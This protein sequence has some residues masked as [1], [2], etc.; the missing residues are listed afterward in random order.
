MPVIRQLATINAYEWTLFFMQCT[1]LGCTAVM[2]TGSAQ[3]IK[4]FQR[5]LYGLHAA[6]QHEVA[7]SKAVVT[8]H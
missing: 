6:I 5:C 4:R 2:A 1:T 7:L 3:L 8:Q